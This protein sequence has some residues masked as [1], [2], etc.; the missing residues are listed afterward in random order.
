MEDQQ[1]YAYQKLKVGAE[2]ETHAYQHFETY[3]AI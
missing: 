3:I 2:A 1:K